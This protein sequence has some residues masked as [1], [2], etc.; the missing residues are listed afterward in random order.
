MR[1]WLAAVAVSTAAAILLA[2]CASGPAGPG[3]GPVTSSWV[4]ST[5]AQALALARH[6]LAKLSFPPGTR[7][8]HVRSLPSLLR[9]HQGPG[10][11]WAGGQE[12][13]IAPGN[14]RSV[15]ERL[16]AHAPF[17]TPTR[18]GP[19]LPTWSGI[20]LPAPEPGIDAAQVSVGIAAYSGTTTLVIAHAYAAWLPARTAAEHLDPFSFRAVT[21][22]EG[23]VIPSPRQVTRTFTDPAVIVRLASFVNG[24]PP[25]P[26]LTARSCAAVISR[27]TLR[28]TAR[29]TNGPAM[30]VSTVEC[31]TDVITVNGK[32]QP[33]L[34]D[35][36]ARLAAMARE[37][38]GMPA[39]A[40]KAES[41][42]YDIG[43]RLVPG[44][45][46]ATSA[47]TMGAV[48]GVSIGGR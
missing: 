30:V 19:A 28:F 47:W 21:V 4:H 23:R 31:G 9:D 40:R 7:P 43:A 18:Y 3:P 41:A 36:H 10:A 48:A 17:S 39:A 37:L 6:L 15:L 34:W 42:Q 16:D 24:L 13:L 12:I 33:G 5:K 46:A 45:A 11:G 20:L 26:A 38:L 14:P 44:P 1:S 27:Y 25:A 8:A 32:P 35:T 22:G 2:G 29:D